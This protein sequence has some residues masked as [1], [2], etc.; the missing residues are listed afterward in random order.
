MLAVAARERAQAVR[1]QELVL[2]E[3]AR[4][5]CARSAVAVDDREAGGRVRA[6]PTARDDAASRELGPVAPGTSRSRAREVAAAGSSSVGVERARR[7]AAG[8]GR[9]SSARAAARASPSAQV[10]H[11]VVEA[12]LVVPQARRVRRSSRVRRCRRSARR[13]WS[14]RPRRRGR[15]RPARA[16]SRSM[17]RQYIAIQRGAVGL[18]EV[19]PS[20]SGALRSNDADVVEAEEA[21]LEDVV[22]LGVLAV[23]PPGEVEQ[24]LVEDALE[25][26]AVAVPVRCR[27]DLDTRAAPPRRA[28]AG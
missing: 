8:S 12:V 13:T 28:P 19:P 22:A 9:P 14:R 24:Q 1:R 11:V 25:E 26:V 2:V 6:R 15:A 18:L 3:H 23:D 16:R 4:A 27:V 17:F 20:G 21:A 5:G 7:R 10:Q